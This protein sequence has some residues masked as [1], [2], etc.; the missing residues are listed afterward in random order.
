MSNSQAISRIVPPLA[1]SL[2]LTGFIF[3]SVTEGLSEAIKTIREHPEL[4][5]NVAMDLANDFAQ[6]CLDQNQ[7]Q[8]ALV[9]ENYGALLK[10]ARASKDERA[11]EAADNF[12]SWK[13]CLDYP[14]LTVLIDTTARAIDSERRYALLDDKPAAIEAVNCWRAVLGDQLFTK[15][16][17]SWRLDALNAAGNG[18]FTNYQLHAD[19]SDLNDGM[20]CYRQ[21]V[22]ESP[23]GWPNLH[24]YL[25]NSAR[26][27]YACYILSGILRD[28]EQSLELCERGIAIAPPGSPNLPMYLS[29][30]GIA[31]G[32][33]YLN[34]GQ[35]EDLE[36]AIKV[37]REGISQLPPDSAALSVYLNQLG[38]N[39]RK[40]FTR[41]GA[42]DDIQLAVS[43]QEES[44]ERGLD[45]TSEGR[46]AKFT[47]LGN[48][49]LDLYSVTGEERDLDRAVD[50]FQ[51]AVALTKT[52]SLFRPSRFNNLGNGLR[53]RYSHTGKTDDLH[54]S[55]ENYKE[56]IK[57]TPV[58]SPDLPSRF[59]NLA[60]A[61][62]MYWDVT[63]KQEDLLE[64]I[65][66]YRRAARRGLEV[67]REWAL[68]AGLNWGRWASARESWTEA[69]EAY[70]YGM[71]AIDQLFHTQLLRTSKETWLRQAQRLPSEAAYAFARNSDLEGAV[72]ALERGRVCLLA[73]SLERA[74]ADLGRLA[75]AG[76]QDL[77]HRYRRAARRLTV[78]EASELGQ[79]KALGVSDLS[80]ELRS[81][82]ADLDE[83][84]EA[85]RQIPEYENFLD[86]PTFN[87]IHRALTSP[88]DESGRQ[89]VGVY[90]LAAPAGGLA[91]IVHS[92][93][94]KAVWLELDESELYQLLISSNEGVA[95]GYLTAQFDVSALQDA[96]NAILPTVGERIMR[97]VTASLSTI[98][99]KRSATGNPARVVLIPTGLLSLLPLHAARYRVGKQDVVAIDE[100]VLT[101]ATSAR[102]L[103][104]SRQSV[105][106]H[107][108]EAP[109]LFAF[110]NPLPLPKELESLAFA[111]AEVQEVAKFFDSRAEVLPGTRASLEEVK[112]R[113]GGADYLHFSCHGWFDSQEPMQSALIL[114]NGDR[115]TLADLLAT[116]PFEHARLAV[117]SACQTAITDFN[118]LPEEAVG[119]PSGF[120]QAGVP[121][122]IG[123]LWSVNDLST[124]ILMKQFYRF[125]LAEGLGIGSALRN[126]QRWLRDSTAEEM[127]L[128]D[129]W[130]Q[131]YESSGRTDASA[132]RLMRIYRA[133]PQLRPFQH[134]Y[135]WGAFTCNG[136]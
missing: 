75:E 21:A 23:F 13:N 99:E 55:I 119:L 114:S 105:S 33:R 96:L 88:A 49:R 98:L 51:Q 56:A 107:R 40:R 32:T 108:G 38:S 64:A 109:K 1:E 128:G 62:A 130:Q 34:S 6:F 135:Y 57:L 68:S 81:V 58:S 50:V 91:L 59:Y 36:R 8:A 95:S 63:R 69:V 92:A 44:I 26:A 60:S 66:N 113:L 110:G 103:A 24:K 121:G 29:F 7:I 78:L 3:Y 133:N 37:Q 53:S 116:P 70:Q 54:G 27:N 134:P 52:D 131:E 19:R 101:Y 122:V 120:M 125:H 39:Y 35:I 132:F 123:S 9:F 67:A 115:L 2:K 11:S 74:R 112:Q 87:Q 127:K 22:E 47:N 126:A 31:L 100:F 73:D 72:T 43:L 17:L 85:I 104:T 45:D 118:E 4:L 10:R 20:D 83:A 117:L 76:H 89:T 16:P 14:E 65:E 18:F 30:A 136:I 90:L 46:A 71:A 5:S 82:R 15:T 97:P 61:L 93:G 106:S 86:A 129:Y 124:A 12:P 48:S 94:V 111:Q 77:Y 102:V 41:T 79:R 28:L 80:N 25:Y 42:L 84:V